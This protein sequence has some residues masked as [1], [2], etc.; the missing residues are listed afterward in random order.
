MTRLCP[1]S[2]RSRPIRM[3]ESERTIPLSAIP[4]FR[5]SK[6]RTHTF[7]GRTLKFVPT[8]FTQASRSIGIPLRRTLSTI[9]CLRYPPIC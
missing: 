1:L 9:I 5:V 2:G 7:Y 8:N 6:V 4:S 3:G